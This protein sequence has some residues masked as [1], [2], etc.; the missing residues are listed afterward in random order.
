MCALDRAGGFQ[1][2][3][4]SEGEFN[5]AV[6]AAESGTHIQRKGEDDLGTWRLSGLG[7]RERRRS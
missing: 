6:M 2:Y 4:P 1:S 5:E 7:G 3:R